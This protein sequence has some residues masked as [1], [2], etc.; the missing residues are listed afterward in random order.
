MWPKALT[1]SGARRHDGFD[2][3]REEEIEEGTAMPLTTAWCAQHTGEENWT[4]TLLACP[5]HDR[6]TVAT[7]SVPS[8]CLEKILVEAPLSSASTA[9]SANF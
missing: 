9:F 4:T 5:A 6:E 1:S 7:I 3:E 8:E 2:S